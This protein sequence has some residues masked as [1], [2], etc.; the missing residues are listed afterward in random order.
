MCRVLWRFVTK[1]SINVIREKITKVQITIQEI[2]S[3]SVVDYQIFE[4]VTE[5]SEVARSIQS[6][7]VNRKYNILEAP[8]E[9]RVQ[10]NTLHL[11][12]YKLGRA[13]MRPAPHCI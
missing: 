8:L 1:H 3:K 9:L 11:I 12:R 2:A 13:A 7:T 5:D 10:K 6:G 4:Y